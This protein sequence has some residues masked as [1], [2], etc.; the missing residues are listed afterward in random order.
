MQVRGCLQGCRKLVAGN[1]ELSVS[2]AAHAID[3]A[4]GASADGIRV[5]T[6]MLGS[7]GDGT[8]RAA[9]DGA[10]VVNGIV[11]PEINDET[12]V[13]GTGGESD[14]RTDLYAERFVG[15]GI[16][17][18]RR[19]CSVGA[20]ASPDI[21]GAGRGSGSARIGH[22]ANACG[23][24][25]GAN[26]IFDFL[27]GVFARDQTRQQNWQGEK[28]ANNCKTS[29]DLHWAAHTINIGIEPRTAKRTDGLEVA[30]THP[31]LSTGST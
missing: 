22:C 1:D 27:L 20:L 6:W 26:V 8:I 5:A 13:L 12:C 11:L 17:D 25:R 18:I 31:D 21:N 30:G 2:V 3:R 14:G 4:G 28:T 9:N 16:G 15:F 19:R 10:F 24:G 7:D 29:V 23:V